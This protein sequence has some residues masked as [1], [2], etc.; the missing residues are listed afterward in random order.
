MESPSNPLLRCV[1]L[2]EIADLGHKHGLLTIVDNTLAAPFN[3]TP[4]TAGFGLV[5]HSATKYLNGPSDADAGFVVGTPDFIDR[6]RPAA[7]H[8]GGRLDARTCERVERGM[9]THAL[10][11]ERHYANALALATF[12]AS[13]P[14]VTTVHYPGLQGHRDHAVAS[15]QI[16]VRCRIIVRDG[17][18]PH[19]AADPASV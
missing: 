8:F 3:Q 11:M 18:M 2:T 7:T 5:I 9:K 16:G 15:R 14:A 10:R 6:I 17:V 13:H 12:L 1:D 19:S 4:L